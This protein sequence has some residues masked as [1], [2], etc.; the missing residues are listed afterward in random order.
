MPK[1]K[2]D[3]VKYVRDKAKS[4]YEKGTECRICGETEQLDFHHFYS[5]TPLL[6]QW[7]TKN[8]LNP[9]YIQALRDDFIEEHSAEL[10]DHTVTLCHHAPLKPFTK[11]MAKTLR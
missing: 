8:K 10:Y 4:K 3:A 9:D 2:R 5:L 11:Y 1:L 7:L 6:N